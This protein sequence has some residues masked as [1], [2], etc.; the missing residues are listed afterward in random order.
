M[1]DCGCSFPLGVKQKV[2]AIKIDRELVCVSVS[3]WGP[4]A[5]LLIGVL[6]AYHLAYKVS[7]RKR[8]DRRVPLDTDGHSLIGSERLTSALDGATK[9]NSFSVHAHGEPEVRLERAVKISPMSYDDATHELLPLFMQQ[10]VITVDLQFLRS[11]QA[12]R[13]VDFCSGATAVTS[14]W[15]FRVTDH[16]VVITPY[17]K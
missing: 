13:V 1:C 16:V 5:V 14:G 2:L 9:L 11:E 8:I 3:T 17:R 7:M 4:S 12:A 6:L 15:I 10:K